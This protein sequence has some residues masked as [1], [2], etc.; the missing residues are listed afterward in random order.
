MNI[1][2]Q[3]NGNHLDDWLNALKKTLP[4]ANVRV[5][6]EG[7]TAPADYAIVWKPPVAMLREQVGLKAIFSRGA[8]V[9][10][11]L[12]LAA[13]LPQG[14]PVVRLSDAGM[15]IQMAEYVTHAVL[16][17]FR[18][19]DSY[20]TLART[21]DW[22]FLRPN[23]R[24]AFSIGV[25]GLGV[26]GQRVIQALQHF[27]FTVNGWSRSPKDLPGVSCFSGRENLAAFMQASKV[28]VC[29]L[30]LTEETKG[31]LNRENLSHLPQSAYLI[32]VG[33]GGHLVEA[34]LLPLI[35]QGRIAGATLDVFSEEPLPALHPFWQE[36]RIT[37]TP[38]IAAMTMIE[39]SVVQIAAKMQALEQGMPIT[40]VVNFS[41]GY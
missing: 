26:L 25:L 33:R 12:Q 31:L 34:D 36:P 10:G 14:V 41:R 11:I 15:G 17:Y 32:N 22:R 39:E 30:P 3:D 1:I 18:Q 20:Q 21:A 27:D 4:Q 23:M 40:G 28:L 8:G 19:F 29:I 9:D 2:F 16:R 13:N 6:Q 38:H 24:A 7:D 37:L 5:W 35:Q